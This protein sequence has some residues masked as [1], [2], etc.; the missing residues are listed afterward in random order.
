MGRGSAMPNESA[1][2]FFIG[3]AKECMLDLGQEGQKQLYGYVMDKMRAM[4]GVEAG[5]EAAQK[6]LLY[7]W[8]RPGTLSLNDAD[9][10]VSLVIDKAKNEALSNARDPA[11]AHLVDRAKECFLF[12]QSVRENDIIFLKAPSEKCQP[13][14]L[15][16][17][18]VIVSDYRHDPS[19][20]VGK[21]IRSVQWRNRVDREFKGES[22]TS[23][24]LMRSRKT[25]LSLGIKKAV[26]LSNELCA[27][28]DI[29]LHQ[30]NTQRPQTWLFTSKR[31]ADLLKTNVIALDWDRAHD[32]KQFPDLN[33]TIAHIRSV[34]GRSGDS[35]P[36]PELTPDEVLE[37]RQQQ[38]LNQAFVDSLQE[39]LLQSR[40][41][42]PYWLLR[43]CRI[44][45][46]ETEDALKQ[47]KVKL[48]WS[49]E[50]ILK[51]LLSLGQEGWDGDKVQRE[52]KSL[53]TIAMTFAKD[54]GNNA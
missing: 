39:H 50:E 35:L 43:A 52:K 53:K 25:L 37:S 8:G 1:E 27:S 12:A 7:Y 5:F 31:W 11:V 38:L 2:P 26:P 17:Y 46:L 6:A 13:P 32:L 54:G 49:I 51:K 48:T 9:H 24:R 3:T 18:G 20:A 30:L 40:E 16:G 19:C 44:D 23:N 15:L 34:Y 28:F 14:K 4:L 29:N 41:W 33:R 36:N 47:T 10:F 22:R 45:D 42:G 21:H